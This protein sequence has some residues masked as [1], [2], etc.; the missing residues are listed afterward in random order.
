MVSRVC[1]VDAG[2]MFFQ[3][4]ENIDNKIQLKEIRNAFVEL[5]ASED[6]EQ[7]LQQN[8]WQYVHDGKHYYV[9]GEDS[10]RVARMFPGKVELRRPMQGGVLNKG[11]DKKMLVMAKMIESSIGK[12]PDDNSLVCTCVSSDPID[13]A[14]DNTFHKARLEGMF[15]RLG[16]HCKVIEEGHAVVL[17]EKP[18]ITEKDGK[19]IPFSGI[20]I[21]FGA[22]KVNCVLVYRGLSVLGMSAARSGDWIDKKVS[23][24][25]DKSLSQVTHIKENDLDF[26]NINYD[27]D[28]I[29]A[30][31]A[32]YTTMI[33]YVFKNFAK[34]FMSVKSEFEAPLDVVIAGGTSMPKGFKEKVESVIKELDLPFEIKRVVQSKDPR[35]AVVKG[36]LTQAIISQK[37]L[38]DNKIDKELDGEEKEDG[39]NKQV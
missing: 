19:T 18:S 38:K 2:T 6:I 35:N 33:E 27:D 34:K 16:W 3:V 17:A 26:N 15:K 32:Y 12:A 37:K 36:L 22:G 8:D 25:T 23:E 4:A 28:V 24:H 5:E 29:F 7:V 14:V 11:E 9:L 1:S 20:G 10:M 13:G 31:D 30:L 21:S 39:E